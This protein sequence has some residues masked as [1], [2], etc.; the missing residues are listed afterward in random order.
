M[1][2]IPCKFVVMA[3]IVVMPKGPKLDG[4]LEIREPN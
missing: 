2:S 4:E 3:S 1:F